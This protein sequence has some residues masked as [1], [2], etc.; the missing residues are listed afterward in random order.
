MVPEPDCG[1]NTFLNEIG[2]CQVIDGGCEPDI[3]GDT[4]WCG[5]PDES[6]T[7]GPY[8]YIT[9]FVL[10]L[11]PIVLVVAFILGIRYWRKRK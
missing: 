10:I 8:I 9:L 3:N 2:V 5:V 1:P 6:H 4:F 11:I 7:A